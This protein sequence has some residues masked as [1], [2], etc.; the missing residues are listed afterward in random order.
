MNTIL[1]FGMPGGMEWMI[2]LAG[3]FFVCIIPLIALI[4]IIRNDFRGTNDRVMWIIIVLFIPFLGSLLYFLIGRNQRVVSQIYLAEHLFASQPQTTP[5]N[6]KR[7]QGLRLSY[8]HAL[9]MSPLLVTDSSF[10]LSKPQT[11]DFFVKRN[12]P[13]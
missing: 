1:L 3:L 7:A 6:C 5:T 13:L 4:D 10:I 9:I 2:I 12:A 11:S 8:F